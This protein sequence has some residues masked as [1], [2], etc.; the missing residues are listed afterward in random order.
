MMK[1]IVNFVL[2]CIYPVVGFLAIESKEANQKLQQIAPLV[3]KFISYFTFY[4]SA[5]KFHGAKRTLLGS[6][7]SIVKFV[8]MTI[9]TSLIFYMNSQQYTFV[10]MFKLAQNGA[11]LRIIIGD[12]PEIFI[13][14]VILHFGVAR[15]CMKIPFFITF[16]LWIVY[17]LPTTFMYD[18]VI[19]NYSKFEKDGFSFAHPQAIESTKKF[20]QYTHEPLMGVAIVSTLF[21]SPDWEPLLINII[22]HLVA[23]FV[24]YFAALYASHPMLHE[25]RSGTQKWMPW[26]TEKLKTQTALVAMLIVISFHIHYSSRLAMMVAGATGRKHILL[27]SP[28]REE[29][30]SHGPAQSNSDM[31]KKEK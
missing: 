9:V 7:I 6:C 22:D 29:K 13:A 21:L 11:L 3:G 16:L 17:Y 1:T 19:S 30:S 28:F 12:L 20:V 26:T 27:Q 31:I 4:Y 25:L 24:G 10:E 23:L 2:F 14:L 18:E 8:L 5:F 15:I